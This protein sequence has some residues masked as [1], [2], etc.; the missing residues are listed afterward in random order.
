MAMTASAVFGR[1][2]ATLSP[3]PTPMLLSES[4]KAAVFP[5][6]SPHETLP[7]SS[8]SVLRMR[9]VF[10]WSRSLKMCSA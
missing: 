7:V 4:A 6:S 10:P 8:C 2:A 1:Y 9:A 3:L 5:C